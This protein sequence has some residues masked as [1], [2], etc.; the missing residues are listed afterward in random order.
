M[1]RT[2]QL[3]H[4]LPANRV[5][6]KYYFCNNNRVRPESGGIGTARRAFEEAE[7]CHVIV[8][9]ITSVGF[10]LKAEFA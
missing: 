4:V 9:V 3:C 1:P 6:I 2:A 8:D 5:I 7:W 10:G